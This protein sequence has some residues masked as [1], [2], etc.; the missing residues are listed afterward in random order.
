MPAG[1]DFDREA[2]DG[3]KVEEADVGDVVYRKAEVARGDDVVVDGEEEEALS[4]EVDVHDAEGDVH[5]AEVEAHNEAEARGEAEAHDVEVVRD[6]AVVHGVEVGRDA[7]AAVGNE[8][9]EDD[10]EAGASGTSF[11]LHMDG[12]LVCLQLTSSATD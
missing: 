11:S 5:G 6:V 2:V 3:E 1:F 12:Y 10:E 9:F 4:D 7:E 8:D